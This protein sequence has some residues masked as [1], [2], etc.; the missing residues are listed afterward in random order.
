V[1]VLCVLLL[2]NAVIWTVAYAV[3][4]GFA[5]GTGTT[6]AP[7]GVTAGDVPAFP[8]LAALPGAG[9][10]PPASLLLLL[11]PLAAGV[12]AGV[13]VARSGA[14]RPALLALA[15]GPVV[16]VVVLVACWLAGG[17]MG[18]G[19]LATAGPNP[20]LAG[21]AVTEWVGLGAAAAA[22]AYRRLRP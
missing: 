19:R 5:V 21:L 18:P 9:G 10:A 3:G 16:G 4:T 14:A 1:L 15:S 20:W 7:Y 17:A 11:G 6:V 22:A 13:V 12:V 8:L 2:P